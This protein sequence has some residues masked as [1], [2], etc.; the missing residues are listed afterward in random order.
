[1]YGKFSLIS[2]FFPFFLLICTID[3]HIV[4]LYWAGHSV[5]IEASSEAKLLWNKTVVI[6]NYLSVKMLL[7]KKLLLSENV[8]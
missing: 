4:Q 1:M 6:Q 3:H 2:S 8:V 7:S 5:T